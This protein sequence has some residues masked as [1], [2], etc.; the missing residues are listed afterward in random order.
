M[1]ALFGSSQPKQPQAAQPATAAGVTIKTSCYG[2]VM[3]VVV[4]SS[5]TT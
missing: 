3:S 4:V 2:K 1:A 5:E